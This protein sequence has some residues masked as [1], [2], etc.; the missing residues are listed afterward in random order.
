MQLPGLVASV[1]L[2]T[3]TLPVDTGRFAASVVTIV[4]S[5][6]YPSANNASAGL[7]AIANATQNFAIK[8]IGAAGGKPQ[9]RGLA[10]IAH[11]VGCVT[12]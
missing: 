5:L 9:V 2:N 11:N 6:A 3:E 10:G 4:P 1:F 8:F 12:W 7:P